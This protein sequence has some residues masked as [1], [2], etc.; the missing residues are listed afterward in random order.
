MKGIVFNI[1]KF[2]INDGPGIRTTV[3]LKG[4]PLRCKWCHN[5][6]SHALKP[7]LCYSKDKCVGCGRCAAVCLQH[8]HRFEEGHQI[9]RS[10]C[11]ACGACVKECNF[12]ALELM[13]KEMSVQEV[14]EEV[15]K[16]KAFYDNSGGGLTLSGGEPLMHME[17]VRELLEQAKQKGLHTCIETCG[18]VKKED[19]LEIAT[20]IDIFLYDW[21]LTDENLHKEY[22]GVSN[23]QIL[24]NLK[25]LDAAGS[26]VIL[27]CPLIPGVNDTSEHFAGIASV[28]NSLK[29][30][31][32][33][34]V[35]PYH[36]LGNDKY[37]RLGKAEKVQN[38]GQPTEHQVKDWMEQIQ[39]NTQ[40]VVRKA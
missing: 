30:V 5:P 36:S 8:A 16:D 26:K 31:L 6:E 2:C 24:E 3:F 21:K 37:G 13:G 39:K 18:F 27:R 29:N 9:D 34:E 22:T 12:D 19:I 4:C 17:F 35:E 7:E 38:F 40:I 20:N 25:A 33:I 1:Q 32:A 14:L 15:M 10:L 28:A 11:A 23:Q